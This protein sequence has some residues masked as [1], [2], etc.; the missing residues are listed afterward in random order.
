MYIHRP[1]LSLVTV[2][3]P[4]LGIY[5]FLCGP[6]KKPAKKSRALRNNR[7]HQRRQ[8]PDRAE[9]E[10]MSAGTPENE[11]RR[12]NVNRTRNDENDNIEDP[13]TN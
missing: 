8:E 12:R 10:T 2:I 7:Q 3:M 11:A 4:L 1:F 9:V 13:Y 6:K 5:L